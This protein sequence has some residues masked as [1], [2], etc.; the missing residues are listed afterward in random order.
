[1]ETMAVQKKARRRIAAAALPLLKN[2]LKMLLLNISFKL[3]FRSIPAPNPADA[4]DN[5][6]YDNN[7]IH[8]H[9]K[10]IIIII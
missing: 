4:P 9:S 5:K 1:M 3:T 8:K 6:R 7:Y 10:I 2:E